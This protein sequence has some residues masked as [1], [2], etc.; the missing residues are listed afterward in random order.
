MK[1]QKGS[2]TLFEVSGHGGFSVAAALLAG[3][4][5]IR[6]WRQLSRQRRQLAMLSDATLKDIGLSRADIEMETQRPFWDDP[7]LH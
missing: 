7:R 5:R 2:V 3:L 4:R 1:G 6:R